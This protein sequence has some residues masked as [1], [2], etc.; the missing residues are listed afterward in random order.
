MNT[1]FSQLHSLNAWVLAFQSADLALNYCLI[2]LQTDPLIF[3]I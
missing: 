2:I 3:N 1:R